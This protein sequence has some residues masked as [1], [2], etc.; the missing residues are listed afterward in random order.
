ME[1]LPVALRCLTSPFPLQLEPKPLA[2]RGHSALTLCSLL[3]AVTRM[4][5]EL[6]GHTSKHRH[7][8]SQLLTLLHT[9]RHATH[10]S[11]DTL[12]LL[13][14][15]PSLLSFSESLPLGVQCLS[16]NTATIWAGFRDWLNLGVRSGGLIAQPLQ[17]GPLRDQRNGNSA[18]LAPKTG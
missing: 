18:L 8:A 9:Q 1:Y 12:H 10:P 4:T 13:P 6:L 15:L 16:H 11:P 14:L 7:T 2:L 3:V 17:S 5:G